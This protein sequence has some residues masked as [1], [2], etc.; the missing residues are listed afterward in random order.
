MPAQR[1]VNYSLKPSVINAA[2]PQDKPFVLTDGGGLYIE[3]LPGGSKVWRYSFRLAGKRPKLTIGPYPQIGIAQ[4]RNIH[5]GM[6]AL[7]G[8]GIDPAQEKK[9]QEDE[10]GEQVRR[11]VTFRDFSLIW[12][13][14]TLTHLSMNYRMQSI[15]F[16]DSYICPVIGEMA[17][18]DVKPRNVLAILEKYKATPTTADRCRSII[19][20]IYNFAIRKLLLDTNPATPLRGAIVVPPK[21]H[22]RH[23]SEK[24]LAVFWKTL[25][26]Q[27]S[28]TVITTY[29][30]KLLMLTMVRKSELRLSKWV[31][32]DLKE[33]RWDIPADRMKMRLPHRVW[34]SRQAMELLQ[35]L[36]K[37]T[38]HG[39]YLFPTRFAGA[40]DLPISGT[41]LNHLFKR[42]DFGVPEFSPHGTRGTAA[43][44]LREHGFAK[45]V[46]ELLLAHTERDQSAAA[47]SHMELA[48]ERRRALQ[49]LADKID[50]LTSEPQGAQAHAPAQ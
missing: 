12:V 5:E 40:G 21:T 31:E 23:L 43:T 8:Q 30:A 1:H 24:E 2:K 25:E 26:K 4:A 17:L 33:G 13:A 41:T 50:E 9:A 34:L 15:R 18:G 47:Y 37:I 14:E 6:R 45:D 35:L 3:V 16:L 11:S 10:R 36:Q 42:L 44:L 38:G 32:F 22:H 39:E 28:A 46:V 7:V 19:Q 29:A 20:Q 49:F 48:A 27:R